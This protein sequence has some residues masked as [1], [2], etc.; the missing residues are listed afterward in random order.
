[1]RSYPEKPE[2][3]QSW[4]NSCVGPTFVLFS[5]TMD[6]NYYITFNLRVIDMELESR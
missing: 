5:S 3:D 1:M 4:F 2:V 6:Y